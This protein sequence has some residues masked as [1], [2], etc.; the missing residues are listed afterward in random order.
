MLCE[1]VR[2]CTACMHDT[3]VCTSTFLYVARV[4][5]L[6]MYITR[7]EVH[8]YYSMCIIMIN[9]RIYCNCDYS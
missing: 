9:L 4:Y 2:V 3:N 1:R 5:S 7:T 6:Y 8:H